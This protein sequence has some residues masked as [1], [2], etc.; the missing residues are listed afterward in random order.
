VN[1]AFASLSCV[2]ADKAFC[3]AFPETHLN[4]S[5]IVTQRLRLVTITLELMHAER[6]SY[7]SLSH[8]LD[9]EVP[10]LWPPE[11]WEPHVFVFMEK[12]YVQSPQTL[13]WNRY[14]VL[15][16]ENPVLIGTM[17]GFPRSETEAEV[18]YSILE[19]WRRRGLAT[20]GLMALMIKLF[21]VE[22]LQSISAQTFP[23]LTPSVRV[24]EKCGFQLNGA[25]EEAGAVRYRL[26][27]PRFEPMAAPI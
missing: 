27:R 1:D 9:A 18:G 17:G 3:P 23:V 26:E 7:A 15:R 13:G 11:H 5:D 12:Q 16:D 2:V 10:S 22:R 19:P 6:A 4:L 24:L 14:V 20:E 25:G 8:L 21:E